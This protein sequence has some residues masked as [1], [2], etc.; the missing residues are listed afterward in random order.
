MLCASLSDAE[1]CDLIPWEW[2]WVWHSVGGLSLLLQSTQKKNSFQDDSFHSTI[3]MLI[4]FKTKPN[5]SFWTDIQTLPRRHDWFVFK[6]LLN[7]QSVVEAQM[8]EL[9]ICSWN[10]HITFTILQTCISHYIHNRKSYPTWDASL[11]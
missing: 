6:Y 3:I 1:G 7:D 4:I 2:E 10:W 11:H 8:F 5:D 9:F